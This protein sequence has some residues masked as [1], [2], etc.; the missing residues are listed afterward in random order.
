LIDDATPVLNAEMFRFGDALEHVQRPVRMRARRG[1]AVALAAL[2]IGVPGAIAGGRALLIGD[3]DQAQIQPPPGYIAPRAIGT[4]VVVASGRL[5]AGPWVAYAVACG[6]RAGVVIVTPDGSRN[7]AACGGI[8]PGAQRKVRAFAPSTLYDGQT[9]TTF[10]YATVPSKVNGVAVD[11]GDR[12]LELSSTVV[13]E[14]N[15]A[16]KMDVRFIVA[17]VPGEKSV[18]RAI[19]RP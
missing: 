4:G 12:V 8:R 16:L 6:G 18:R 5:D 14:A 2:A 11:L 13:P 17:A 3:G 9:R 10:I 19:I 1:L 15:R 7:G